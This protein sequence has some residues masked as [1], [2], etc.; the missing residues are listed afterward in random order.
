MVTVAKD[1]ARPSNLIEVTAN[2]EA[3]KGSNKKK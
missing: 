2:K 1:A 3:A